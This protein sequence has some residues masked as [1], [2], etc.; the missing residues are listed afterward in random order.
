M[1]NI[2]P[3]VVFKTRVKDETIEG[4]N[5]YIWKDKSSDASE[6]ILKDLKQL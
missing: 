6:N 1:R 5:P 4:E 2:V 3:D